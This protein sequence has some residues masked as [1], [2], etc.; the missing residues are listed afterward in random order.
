LPSV[1]LQYRDYGIQSLYQFQ[2]IP[3][4][5][6][7]RLDRAHKPQG[8]S[9]NCVSQLSPAASNWVSTR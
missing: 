2:Y 1:N 3:Y 6:G 4:D 8:Q 9:Q 7:V 5:R